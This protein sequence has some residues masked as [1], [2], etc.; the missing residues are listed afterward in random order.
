MF[1]YPFDVQTCQT[2]F[3]MEEAYEDFV[4][5]SLGVLKY[6]GNLEL[7]LYIIERFKISAG[8]DKYQDGVEVDITLSRG[9]ENIILNTYLPTILLLFTVFASTWF[10]IK[11]FESIMGLNLTVMLLLVTMFDSVSAYSLLVLYVFNCTYNLN[12]Y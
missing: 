4:K 8:K 9:L 1:W 6:S 5:L 11:Y 7:N 3:I 10:K 12:V 2:V